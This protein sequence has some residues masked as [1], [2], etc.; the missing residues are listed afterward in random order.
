MAFRRLEKEADE[1]YG[2]AKTTVI[3]LKERAFLFTEAAAIYEKITELLFTAPFHFEKYGDLAERVSSKVV[4]LNRSN[5]LY[6]RYDL[7]V[8][9]LTRTKTLVHINPPQ[10]SDAISRCK[11]IRERIQELVFLE[12]QLA[13][14]TKSVDQTLS[15]LVTR[16][17]KKLER[18]IARKNNRP[19]SPPKGMGSQ[20]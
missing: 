7:A 5:E 10:L 12:Q 4:M 3:D 8:E 9:E 6:L 16:E 13:D 20:N 1:L 11:I 19:I 2:K 15:S 17:L 14:Q 18:S